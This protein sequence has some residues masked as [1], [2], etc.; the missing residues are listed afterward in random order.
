MKS[1]KLKYPAF[2]KISRLLGC[3]LLIL[4]IGAPEKA[5][6]FDPKDIVEGSF[7]HFRGLTSH[8]VVEMT[9]HRPTW[10]RSMT[11]EA[12]T[13]GQRDSLFRITAPPKDQDNGTLKKGREMWMYNPKVNRVIKVPPSM[14][15]QSWMGS[16]FSNNDLA[17]SDSLLTDYTHELVGQET[18]DGLKVYIIRS[19]PKPAAPVV[20]GMQELK[21]REDYILLSE[22]F[23]DEDLKPVKRMWTLEIQ[24]LGGRNFPKIWRMEKTD[25]EGEY[26]ELNYRELE[27]DITLP[28]NLFTLSNLK[29]PRR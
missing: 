22:I 6:A 8:S 2:E 5:S 20:W 21:I 15:S 25:A 4:A 26:T 18:N 3:F 13:I 10:E 1:D 23:Y 12:W 24:E 17:K 27:F 9:I 28:K 16:D 29:N 14:M 11:I 19:T 7:E